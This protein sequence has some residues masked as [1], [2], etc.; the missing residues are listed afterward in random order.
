MS[1]GGFLDPARL[2]AS[3][4]AAKKL[5]CLVDLDQ[6]LLDSKALRNE[7]DPYKDEPYATHLKH[8]DFFVYE[9]TRDSTLPLPSRRLAETT[10]SNGS[11]SN[12][13]RSK[14]I[15]KLR[16]HS[17]EFLASLISRYYVVAYTHASLEY[18]NEAC[19]KLDPFNTVFGPARHRRIISKCH[20][21][22]DVGVKLLARMF[23]RSDSESHQHR[24]DELAKLTIVLDDNPDVWKTSK[25]PVLEVLQH[26]F[27]ANP[28]ERA[29][30]LRRDDLSKEAWAR[31]PYPTLL[32]EKEDN[33]NLLRSLRRVLFGVHSLMYEYGLPETLYTLQLL[34]LPVLFGY[35][36]VFDPGFSDSWQSLVESFGGTFLNSLDKVVPERAKKTVV[37]PRCHGSALHEQVKQHPLF[38][39][40]NV[41]RAS[42]LLEA[43]SHW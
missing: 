6:T 38:A 40:L 12:V 11:N 35:G 28:G 41:V 3:L 24:L 43:S 16:P 29:V 23:A 42:W 25:L 27:W 4:R 8:K 18:A 30:V 26:K 39:E 7:V 37:L 9:M 19:K 14:H 33:D 13:R 1:G 21:P 15:I 10:S 2:I 5:L 36:I 17:R 22:S 31:S 34:R 32:L 20:F